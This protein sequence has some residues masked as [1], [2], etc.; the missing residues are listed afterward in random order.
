MVRVA[1]SGGAAAALPFNCVT[2]S[3]GPA[4]GG[5]AGNRGM[6]G[7][8]R[9]VALLACLVKTGQVLRLPMALVRG[10]SPGKA[11]WIAP[12]PQARWRPGG[13]GGHQAACSGMDLFVGAAGRRRQAAAEPDGG[14]QSEARRKGFSFSAKCAVFRVRTEVAMAR[15]LKTAGTAVVGRHCRRRRMAGRSAAGAADGRRWICRQDRLLECLHRQ[16]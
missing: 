4:D 9:S 12:A 10:A 8:E 14:Q 16:T 2:A 1:L 11:K 7:S 3:A 13:H 5:S 6:H 15:L